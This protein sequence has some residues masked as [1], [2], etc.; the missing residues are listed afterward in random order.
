MSSVKVSSEV[1]FNVIG[2]EKNNNGADF[3][4]RSVSSGKDY[5]YQIS[6]KS[7][8]GKWYTHVRV[9]MG[10][11]QFTYLGTYFNGAIWRKSIK[12]DTPS[13]VAIAFVLKRVEDKD[14]SWLDERVDV[15]HKGHCLVCGKALTDAN[16]IERG[17]GPVCANY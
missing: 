7:F 2:R 8:N 17:L 13:A 14:F 15:M 16:S 9:E 11:L 12:I 1:L 3:T 6:R 10:Y 4:I 5:T